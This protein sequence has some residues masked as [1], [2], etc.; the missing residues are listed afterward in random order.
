MDKSPQRVVVIHPILFALY[1][2]LAL[3]ANN[4][5]Q[6]RP[7]D[8]VR[9]ILV[10]LVLG[11]TAFLICR[12][13]I[14][15]WMKAGLVAAILILSFA[16][17]GQIYSMMETAPGLN[18]FLG[19]HRFLA[20]LWLTVT[21]LLTWFVLRQKNRLTLPNT[22]LNVVSI[23]L[24][25]MPT[26]RLANNAW[27]SYRYAHSNAV[28]VNK[29]SNAAGTSSINQPDVYYIILDMYARDDILF[30]RFSYDN[31]SFLKELEDMGF[32]VA[33]CSVTNYN[34]TELSL[35]SSFN[36]N[37]LDVLGDQYHSGSTD[38]SGLPSLI[39]QSAVRQIFQEMGYQFI[40]FETGFTFTE[41][42]DA[43]FFLGPSPAEYGEGEP[44]IQMNAFE[45]ML[46]K[47]TAVV[48]VTDAQAKWADQVNSALDTRKAHIV[49]QVYLMDKLPK[50][51]QEIPGP[52]FV[53]AH[54]LIPHPPFVFSKEG[55]NLSFPGNDGATTYGPSAKDFKVGYRNQLDYINA[56]LIP[57]LQQ[58]IRDSK[59]PPV[60]IIQGDH[61][62][63]P[64]R[65]YNLNAYYFPGDAKKS[66]YASISP[67]N[68]FRLVLND[69]FGG[70]YEL[71]PDINYA[72]SDKKPFDFEK[73]LN[74]RH[75]SD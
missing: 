52:K 37:Y 14:K 13:I 16:S 23:A 54:I 43:D 72:S 28:S 74:E 53:Y 66:L 25:I 71:L 46:A 40:N 4:I 32:F 35:A 57:I 31:S 21:V 3:L 15:D 75:C 39:H 12:L 26:V 5:L 73:I 70:S 58:I 44:G 38:R 2:P 59:T 45:S 20:P 60:I 51:S 56:A 50:L 1:P 27:L 10:F 47:T 22:V 18:E 29:I 30:E 69:Y 61:G 62:V 67:V 19:R 24:F 36:M 8:A 68:T 41:V 17:Y 48:L 49:R 42:R 65:S 55:I 34:M 9:S 6:I 7:V 64:K 33:R 11:V 63:D